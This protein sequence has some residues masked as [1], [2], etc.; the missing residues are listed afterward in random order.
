MNQLPESIQQA[1][2]ARDPVAV[3]T[4]VSAEGVPNTIYVSCCDLTNGPRVLIAD[5]HFGKTRENLREGRSEVSFL[6]FAPEFAAYQ[7]K[8]QVSYFTEG[9]VFEE[10]KAFAKQEFELQ[11]IVE[12]NVTE[13][14]K[15]AEKLI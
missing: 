5:S 2:D 12:I 15:G 14:Y 6:F 9:P 11:G 8:G 7:L 4:T 13:V 3:L 1:W 10:G